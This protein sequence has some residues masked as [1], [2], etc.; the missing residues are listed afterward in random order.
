VTATPHSGK[1]ETF[2][3]LI[4]LL[5]EGLHD[6]NLEQP[7]ERSRL[8]GYFVQRRRADI[9]KYLDDETPFPKDRQTKEAAYAL[10]PGY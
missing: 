10:T 6:I 3:N 4:G 2:R 9:R 8:A 1:D 5:D 7:A